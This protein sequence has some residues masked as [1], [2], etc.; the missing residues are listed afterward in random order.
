MHRQSQKYKWFSERADIQ[1]PVCPKLQAVDRPTHKG[2]PALQIQ[3]WGAR[4]AINN[5]WVDLQVNLQLFW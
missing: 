4:Y 1:I 2:S 3:V 5:I